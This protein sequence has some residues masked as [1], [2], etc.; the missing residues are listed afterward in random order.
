MGNAAARADGEPPS[1][2]SRHAECVAGRENGQNC[3]CR[4]FPAP[5]HWLAGAVFRRPPGPRPRPAAES[6]PRHASMVTTLD[7]P[8]AA[9]PAAARPHRG[10]LALSLQEAFT[11]AVRL[12]AR[13]QRVADADT[14]RAQIKHLLAI[15]SRDAA[16]A[17]YDPGAVKLAGYAYVA[18]LDE[19]V[20]A[21]GEPGLASWPRQSLQEELFGDHK[22][23]ETFFT[24]L[25]ELL[26]R[27]DS[28][29]AADVLEVFLLCLLLG[30]R[31]RYA[32]GD[33]GALDAHVRTVREKVGRIRGGR[34]PISPL[35]PLPADETAPAERDPW[36]GRLWRA[37]AGTAA[38]AVL[39][40]VVYTLS[41]G[42]WIGE[43]QALA[44]GAAR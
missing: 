38:L 30:F 19:S 17:G 23:G 24:Y 27:Q 36:V 3:P 12:R 15:A 9:A 34:E 40:F 13:R 29:E 35:W 22:A 5:V 16:Q 33:R 6:L 31:G 25:D 11:A 7:P 37:A 8:A 32:A 1:R 26:A 20:L 21:S 42:S 18:F 39:L 2:S 43:I 4:H 14:F 44:P 10:E 41:L 28:D